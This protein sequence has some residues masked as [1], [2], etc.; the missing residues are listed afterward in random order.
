[1]DPVSPERWQ[2]SPAMTTETLGAGVPLHHAYL[3]LLDHSLYEEGPELH[4]LQA[5]LGQADGVEDSSRDP[6]PLL[7]FRWRVFLHD[8]LENTGSTPQKGTMCTAHTESPVTPHRTMEAEVLLETLASIPSQVLVAQAICFENS[9][10]DNFTPPC[11]PPG[12]P[13]QLCSRAA[14]LVFPGPSGT[15]CFTHCVGGNGPHVEISFNPLP[16]AVSAPCSV[17]TSVPHK[18][19][20]SR[21]KTYPLEDCLCTSVASRQ[22]SDSS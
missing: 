10:G 11:S 13:C 16:T 7:C 18:A 1:M 9:E 2:G 12:D 17:C 15:S 19:T 4:P 6:V 14:P 22:H 8:A 21:G 20:G 3:Q 5:L